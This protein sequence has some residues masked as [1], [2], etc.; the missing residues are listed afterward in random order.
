MKFWFVLPQ[1]RQMLST[2]QS[3]QMTV[4]NQQ[5]PRS[6]TVVQGVAFTTMRCQVEINSF[7]TNKF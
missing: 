1:L 6:V 4:E 2:R 7:S 3:T 5:P